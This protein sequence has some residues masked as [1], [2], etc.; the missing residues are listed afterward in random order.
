MRV[1]LIEDDRFAE[2]CQ[3]MK[4]EAIA[5]GTNGYLKQQTG[6]T[7]EQIEFAA[8][9][10]HRTIHYHFVRWAQSQGAS[11]VPK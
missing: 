4:A 5:T 8:S 10:I 9:E 11:C 2:I 6:L 1:I 7:K 3:L